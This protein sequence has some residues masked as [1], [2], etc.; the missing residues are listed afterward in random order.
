MVWNQIQ[1][2]AFV[3]GGGFDMEN[4]G[5][6]SKKKPHRRTPQKCPKGPPERKLGES[7][8]HH[9]LFGGQLARPD[10]VLL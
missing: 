10:A 7:A 8:S 5:L 1:S 2:E 4:F 9:N 3:S 6:K